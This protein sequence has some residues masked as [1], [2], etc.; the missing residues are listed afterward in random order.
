VERIGGTVLGGIAAA[1]IA[2]VCTTPLAIAA[3]M[4]PLAILAFA[5]RAVSFGAFMACLTPLVVL[6]TEFSRPGDGEL[7][8]AIAR[9]AYT[10]AGGVLAVAG[11]IL[12]WPS[13]EP[14]RLRA[15]THQRESADSDI[16]QHHRACAD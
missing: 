13:W 4:F 12:L 14:D 11:C 3:A 6:L 10:A 8:I 2:L 7:T 5:V 15:R 16:W 1:L 9:A